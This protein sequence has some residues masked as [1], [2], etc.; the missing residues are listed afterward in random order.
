M[1]IL[2]HVSFANVNKK[3]MTNE[4][5]N[6]MLDIAFGDDETMSRTLN[7]SIKFISHVFSSIKYIYENYFLKE[8]KRNKEI[9]NV[10]NNDTHEK[11]QIKYGRFIPKEDYEDDKRRQKIYDYTLTKIYKW[12]LLAKIGGM[13][14]YELPKTIVLK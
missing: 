12:K 7:I 9:E 1:N 10:L 8:L 4:E 13:H 5:L 14:Y 11:I 3:E 2:F 6:L